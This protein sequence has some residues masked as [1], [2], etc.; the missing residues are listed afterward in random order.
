MEMSPSSRARLRKILMDFFSFDELRSLC[1]DIGIDYE[2][3]RSS[4]KQEFVVELIQLLER[5]N[6]VNRLVSYIGFARPSISDIADLKDELQKA[7]TLKVEISV[8]NSINVKGLVNILSN[9]LNVSERNIA[10]KG[11]EKEKEEE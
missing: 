11:E 10:V 2:T 4:S 5:H 3:I 9:L 6:E 1:F 8:P 7:N